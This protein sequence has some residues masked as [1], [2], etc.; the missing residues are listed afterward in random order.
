MFTLICAG[1]MAGDSRRYRAHYDVTVMNIWLLIPGFLH[2][3]ILS[4]YTAGYMLYK[5]RFL[6]LH[7]D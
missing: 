2:H 3:H 7:E 4:S 6:G 1:T 5:T